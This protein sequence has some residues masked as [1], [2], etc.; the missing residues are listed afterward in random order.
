MLVQPA[1]TVLIAGLG[2]HDPALYVVFSQSHLL[3]ISFE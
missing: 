2:R 1:K 3:Y